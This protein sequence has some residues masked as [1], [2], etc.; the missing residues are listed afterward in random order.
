MVA[1]ELNLGG[2]D[3]G[4]QE[5]S[6][7]F[8]LMAR[9]FYRFSCAKHGEDLFL[10]TGPPKADQRFYQLFLQ[11]EGKDLAWVHGPPPFDEDEMFERWQEG[12]TGVPLIDA[13]MRELEATG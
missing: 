5:R 4:V 8:E 13:L 3:G 6:L 1:R 7:I 10:P 12:M 9:D 2:S 11:T